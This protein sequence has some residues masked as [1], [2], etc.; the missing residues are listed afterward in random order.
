[1][2]GVEWRNTS[3]TSWPV[4]RPKRLRLLRLMMLTVLAALI[5]VSSNPVFAQ[6]SKTS[7]ELL[8]VLGNVPG[9]SNLPVSDIRKTGN[10]T[11]A[12]VTLHGK[13]GRVVGF[14]IDGV[15]MGALVPDAF[16]LT[17]IITIPH[18]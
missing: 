14:K 15:S 9:I 4:N 8:S 3:S 11:S 7:G 13:S 2:N 6:S 12:K 1:M 16:N 5:T 18:G 10:S 17:D